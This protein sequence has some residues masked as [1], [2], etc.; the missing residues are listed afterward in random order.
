MPKRPRIKERRNSM[1]SIAKKHRGHAVKQKYFKGVFMPLYKS[2]WMGNGINN[3]MWNTN[4]D[5]NSATWNTDLPNTTDNST[6]PWLNKAGD[7]NA[8]QC[9]PG[10][11]IY[12]EFSALPVY[13]ITDMTGIAT[14]RSTNLFY[15]GYMRSF[16]DLYQ[17]CLNNHPWTT[18]GYSAHEGEIPS[19]T[20]SGP[21]AVVYSQIMNGGYSAAGEVEANDASFQR[22][23]NS[24][25]MYEGGKQT[26]KFTNTTTL[27]VYIEIREFK[28]KTLMAYSMSRGDFNDYQT[29]IT[30]GNIWVGRY[31]GMYESIYLDRKS[32]ASAW[33]NSSKTAGAVHE[34]SNMDDLFDELDDKDFQYKGKMA[35][36]DM[37]W[38]VGKKQVHRIDPG[39]TFT[40]T[41][42]LP[43]FSIKLGEMFSFMKNYRNHIGTANQAFNANMADSLNGGFAINPLFSKFCSIR[44]WGS[45]GFVSSEWGSPGY[46]QF[47]SFRPQETKVDTNGTITYRNDPTNSAVPTVLN[48][49]AVRNPT[50]MKAGMISHA[51]RLNHTM[52]ESHSCRLLPYVKF[53]A[54]DKF[55]WTPNAT[56]SKFIGLNDQVFAVDPEENNIEGVGGDNGGPESQETTGKIGVGSMNNKLRDPYTDGLGDV[57]KGLE[58]AT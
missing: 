15:G 33:A 37:R 18:G 4:V 58:Y 56:D 8:I 28:P 54:I 42:V 13:K 10:R 30:P 24:T 35:I 31:P 38:R 25:F 50:T 6:I 5:L 32:Q 41:M 45:K 2:S 39:E 53:Y 36:T 22:L 40:Y 16:A 7:L 12:M 9:L 57:N 48:D 47:D 26:H 17:D 55:N 49:T 29:G 34:F 51:A 11:Q 19:A 1:I 52:S 14:S 44:A 20:A 43:P 23:I 27:P 46:D 3:A 21:N